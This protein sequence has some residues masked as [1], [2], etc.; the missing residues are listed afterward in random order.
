VTLM[1][2]L[3][4]TM[5]GGAVVTE[6]IFAWPGLGRLTLEAALNRDFPVIEAGVVFLAIAFNVLNLLTDL[7]YAAI[8][9]RVQV[10]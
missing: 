2:L 6:T 10:S 5:L 4:G 7:T 8:D 3:F 9:P 1:G